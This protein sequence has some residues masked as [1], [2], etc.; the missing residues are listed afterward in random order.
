MSAEEKIEEEKPL[1]PETEKVRRKLV[2]LG[3]GFMGFNMLALMAVLGAI[4][5]KIGGYGD[6]SPPAD[7]SHNQ[8]STQVKPGFAYHL[9]LPNGAQIVSASENDARVLLN[10]RLANGDR[11]LWFFSIASGEMIGKLAIK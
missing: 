9:A 1:D 10:L 5:Y 7:V 2:K 4:V 3:A 11:E 6:D 8:I